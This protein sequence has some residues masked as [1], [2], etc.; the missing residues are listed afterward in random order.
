LGTNGL[1]RPRMQARCDSGMTVGRTGS[2]DAHGVDVCSRL[3]WL[4]EGLA[5]C[6]FRLVS[7]G[8]MGDGL[9]KGSVRRSKDGSKMR[10]CRFGYIWVVALL[11]AGCGGK[12][13]GSAKDAGGG[14]AG[15]AMR[16]ERY[17]A[18]AS[19]SV[20]DQ[21]RT[22]APPCVPTCGVDASTGT[23][24]RSVSALPAGKCESGAS[25]CEMGAFTPCRCAADQG[26]LSDYLCS[27]EG[28]RW[29]CV[30]IVQGAGY[31]A[32]DCAGD[33]GP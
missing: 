20:A 17:A 19:F 31:C 28:Q 1:S 30:I 21:N 11:S 33:G 15:C 3:E 14:A 26:P 24:A 7:S 2:F 22:G 10:R 32:D 29:L 9:T 6:R 23:G 13:V 27:C 8:R 4:V 12:D 5:V 16:S 25:A 18:D